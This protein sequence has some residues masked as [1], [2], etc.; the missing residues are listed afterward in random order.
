MKEDSVAFGKN[1]LE[2]ISAQTPEDNELAV[3][4]RK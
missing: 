1:S 4:H 3:F 2:S